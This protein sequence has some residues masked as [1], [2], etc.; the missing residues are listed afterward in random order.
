MFPCAVDFSNAEFTKR[1]GFER[2]TF[3]EYAEFGGATFGGDARFGQCVFDGGADFSGVVFF[4]NAFFRSTKSDGPFSLA[5]VTF[6]AVPD[7]IQMSFRAPAR[8]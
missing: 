4:K 7:F 5:D 6:L 8:H 3:G 1:A 2:A